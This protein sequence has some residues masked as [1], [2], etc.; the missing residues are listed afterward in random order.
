MEPGRAALAAYLA[1]KYSLGE[2]ADGW[3]RVQAAYQGSDRTQFFADLRTFLGKAGYTEIPQS[4]Q[5]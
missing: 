2:A 3:R 1:D 4:P 5:R